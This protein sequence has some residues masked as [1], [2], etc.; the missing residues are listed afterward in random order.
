MRC[1]GVEASSRIVFSGAPGAPCY[2]LLRTVQPP[3]RADIFVLESTYGDRLHSDRSDCAQ[4]LKAA[5]DRALE[6]GHVAHSSV[7]TW[8]TQERLYEIED[9]LHRKTLLREH[10]GVQRGDSLLEMDWSRLPVI[11]DSPLAHRITEAYRELHA[12]WNDEARQRLGEKR[13]PL[14]FSQLICVDSHGE[15]QQVV[16]YLKSTGRPAIVMAGNGMCAG[17]RIV[18]YLKAMLGGHE[19]MFVRYQA[20]GGAVIQ[21]SERAEG[22]VQI[23][24]DGRMYEIR[25]KVMT[26]AGYSGHADQD[27]LV[28]L[29][30]GNAEVVGKVLLVHGESSAKK[31]LARVLRR[32]FEFMGR[33]SDVTVA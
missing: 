31:V 25:A 12:F 23:D 2:P 18:S 33:P 20:K 5:I 14:G 21:A 15:H 24:L 13:A 7:R 27:G 10:A 3:Q 17:G 16:S 6:D 32:R 22:V 30:V 26:L 19:V 9:I 8:R 29:V 4:R 1:P 11:L 28:D